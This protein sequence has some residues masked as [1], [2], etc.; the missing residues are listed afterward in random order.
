MKMNAIEI[1]TNLKTMLEHEGEVS[2]WLTQFIPIKPSYIDLGIAA[3]IAWLIQK[4]IIGGI[5]GFIVW[6]ILTVLIWGGLISL[7][8]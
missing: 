1:V 5:I 7:G 4:K 2:L 6:V 8:I 3:L